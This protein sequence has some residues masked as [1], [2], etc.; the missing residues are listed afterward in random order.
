[1]QVGQQAPAVVG[2]RQGPGAALQHV[3]F[4]SDGDLLVTVDVRQDAGCIYGFL[5]SAKSKIKTK[6]AFIVGSVFAFAC[7]FRC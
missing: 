5:T 4:S 1:M 3:A 2:G 6:A 7:V